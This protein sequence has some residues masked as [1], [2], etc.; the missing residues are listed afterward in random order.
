[1]SA[2]I[3]ERIATKEAEIR[4]SNEHF[5]GLSS[6]RRGNERLF[7]G[8]AQATRHGELNALKELRNQGGSDGC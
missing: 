4:K 1:M 5:D 7:H 2:S 6:N 8:H 3:D